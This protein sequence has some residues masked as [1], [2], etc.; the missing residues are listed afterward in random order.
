[1]KGRCVLFAIAVS[2]SL[3]SGCAS[4]TK[5]SKTGPT[6]PSLAEGQGRIWVYWLDQKWRPKDEFAIH[7]NYATVGTARQGGAFYVD[8]PPGNYL[9]E[10]TLI[11]RTRCYVALAAGNTAYVRVTPHFN[12]VGRAYRLEG[13]PESAAL[14]ELNRCDSIVETASSAESGGAS[15]L[16][17][18]LASPNASIV[19]DCLAELE[20]KY[21][22]DTNAWSQITLLLHDSRPKVRRKAAR[23]L[24]A[25]HADLNHDNLNDICAM[26]L[27]AEPGEKID[28]LKSLR[29]L[30]ASEAVPRILPLLNSPNPGIVRDACR[31]LAVLGDKTTIV[32]IE[33]L[34]Q[35]PDKGVKADATDA[36]FQLQRKPPDRREVKK[37]I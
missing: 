33:P 35:H 8:R 31:T 34:L 16:I 30:N 28:A 13:V 14:R 19:V 22:A 18:G 21:P 24:G 9:V 6:A 10:A 20:R 27:A 36:I 26:L 7:I 15:S 23:V 25:V 4:T 37:A 29:G 32:S 3:L 11:G 5:S 2:V 1:M 17:Q 12:P